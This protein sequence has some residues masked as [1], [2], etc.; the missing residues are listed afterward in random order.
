MNNKKLFFAIFT[1]LFLN[2]LIFS[3]NLYFF[4]RSTFS[5][6]QFWERQKV[7]YDGK[8][9]DTRKV[10]S[11][12]FSGTMGVGLEFIIWDIG[13]KNGSR[14]FFKTGTD[15]VL[16][17][18]SYTGAYL[19]RKS[20]D[21]KHNLNELYSLNIN[22]GLFLTGIDWDFYFGGTIP[23]T[24]LIW[25]FGCIWT[26]LFPAYSPKYDVNTFF[27]K[28]HFYA[29]FGYDIHIPNTNF[30]ITPQV[31]AG[32]TCNPLI[33]DDIIGDMSTVG[34]DYEQIDQYSGPYFDF[35][36]AFSFTSFKWK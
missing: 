18:I 13:K 36:V 32:F 26:F 22:G 10:F 31:R 15:L 5:N 20:D 9:D 6:S 3:E 29:V 19:D 2:S 33:A 17:G 11:N 27:E 4:T 30:K 16:S 34:G 14:L 21:P 35:S 24:D 23:K 7:K 25:G 12:L 1:I 8:S 28:W